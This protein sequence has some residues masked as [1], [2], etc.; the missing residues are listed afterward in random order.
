V[1]ILPSPAQRVPYHKF[2]QPSQSIEIFRKFLY[3]LWAVPAFRQAT[4]SAV[5]LPLHSCAL[6]RNGCAAAAIVTA[7]SFFLN[8]IDEPKKN[9]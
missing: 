1:N 7:K 2:L 3:F 6:L 4:L 5:P 9:V 8:L